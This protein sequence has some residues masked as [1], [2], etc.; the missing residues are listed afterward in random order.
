MLALSGLTA[1]EEHLSALR[2]GADGFMPKTSEPADLLHPLLALTQG[3]GVVPSALLRGLSPGT[4]GTAR[5]HGLFT[6]P[7]P[8]GDTRWPANGPDHP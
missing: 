4:C 1:E 2:A 5:F 6:G 3:F 7:R 8:V